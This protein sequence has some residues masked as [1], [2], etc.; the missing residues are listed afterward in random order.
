MKIEMICTGEEVLSGQ[1]VD[2]NAAW[3]ANVLMDSGL[4]LQRKTTVGDR[5]EDLVSIFQDRSQHADV[6]LVN[7]GLGP[8]S[9]DLSAEAAAKALGVELEEDSDWLKHLESWH[10][11][12]NRKMPASNYK[13]CLLPKGAVLVDNPVGSA[14]GFRIKLNR[15]WLFFTPGVPVELKLMVMEQFLP[16]INSEF[17]VSQA[18]QLVKLVTLGQANPPLPMSSMR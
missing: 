7:G 2:T 8:T 4:E 14:P 15:A 17:A 16:F 5:M 11:K 6:I 13:Q 1:I 3:F 18:T 10:S 12:R 9:D